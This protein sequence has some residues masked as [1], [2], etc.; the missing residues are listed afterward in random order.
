MNLTAD[1][2]TTA[3]TVAI[4][5]ALAEATEKAR[6]IMRLAE[7]GLIYPSH[8]ATRLNIVVSNLETALEG[9]ES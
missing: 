7:D 3:H 5:H 2:I 9:V 1:T 6:R 8:A 4:F